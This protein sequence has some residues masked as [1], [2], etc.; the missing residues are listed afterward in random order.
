MVAIEWRLGTNLKIPSAQDIRHQKLNF[1]KKYGFSNFEQSLLLT[2][3]MMF[4]CPGAI[5]R[6]IYSSFQGYQIYGVGSSELHAVFKNAHPYLAFMINQCVNV[7]YRPERNLIY[8]RHVISFKRANWL[9]NNYSIDLCM[10]RDFL[11]R[12]KEATQILFRGFFKMKR[13]GD[14]NNFLCIFRHLG[15]GTLS[16]NSERG[17]TRNK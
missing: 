4:L 1:S 14:K 12:K 11:S 17:N 16:D 15:N 2:N 8:S 13:K 3:S 7:I 5:R 9:K 6:G 10:S